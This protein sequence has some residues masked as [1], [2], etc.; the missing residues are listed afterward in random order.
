MKDLGAKTT[1]ELQI[2]VDLL[3][4]FDPCSVCQGQ[5]SKFQ[6]LYNADIKIYSSG[7]PDGIDLIKKYPKFEVKKPIKK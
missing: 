7:A 6:K 1:D 5:M 4:I 2:K 3:T